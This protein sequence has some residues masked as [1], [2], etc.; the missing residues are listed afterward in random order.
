MRLT[1]VHDPRCQPRS[2]TICDET[3]QGFH[4]IDVVFNQNQPARK[5][6]L[7]ER[8]RT[9][10]EEIHEYFALTPPSHQGVQMAPSVLNKFQ[11]SDMVNP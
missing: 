8:S 3:L 10:N 2:F 11:I 5:S 7:M 1:S 4:I 9:W 6:E